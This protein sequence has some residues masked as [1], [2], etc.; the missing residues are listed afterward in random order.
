VNLPE[1]VER[2]VDL[3]ARNTLALPGRA[4]LYAEITSPAA[5]AT[6]AGS[7]SGRRFI[8]G[9]GSNLVLT[10]DFDG[11]MLH[12]AF[13]GR[14][15][16]GEDADNWYVRAGGGENWHD[17]V[18]W[19]L[20]QGWPGLENLVLIPGTVGAAPI[21]NIGAYGLE[22]AER[23]ESL[24]ACDTRSGRSVRFAR[25][26]CRFAY[27]DSVFK[28]EG[29]H[30]GG[31]LAITAVTF[32]LPKIWRALTRYGGV[33]AELAA[34]KIR[35]AKPNEVAAAIVALR[36]RKLPD[37]QHLPNAGSFFHNPVVDAATAARL[38]TAA[39]DLPHFTQPDGGVKLS[40]GWL[41]EQ[42]GWKGRQLGAVGMYENH[43]L[44]LVNRGGA[45]GADIYA[46]MHAIQRDV[47]AKFSVELAP[48]P[49][50]L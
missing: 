19:T 46:L 42:C 48:E 5:L 12:M 26:D 20:A 3:A 37:P 34:R 38:Q 7:L 16:A 2:D 36:Q 47:R 6:L 28:Q 25:D 24:E 18:L 11:L 14:E 49:V 27:R 13:G 35:A 10:G 32:R 44:V 1:F 9:G 15:L 8:L 23:F 30:V 17:F 40:A 29:W 45:R 39:P 21:Q 43:A 4:A 31:Q 22:F 50:F 33:A 41:V